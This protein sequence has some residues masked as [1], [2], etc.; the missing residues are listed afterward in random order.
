MR[1]VALADGKVALV[2]EN[3]PALTKPVTLLTPEA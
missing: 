1:D 2:A 3:I